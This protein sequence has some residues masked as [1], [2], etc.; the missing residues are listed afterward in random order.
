MALQSQMMRGDSIPR[1]SESYNRTRRSEQKRLVGYLLL[2]ALLVGILLLAPAAAFA[3][4]PL[5][6]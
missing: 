6:L 4:A 3:Q 5:Q 2:V 1:S